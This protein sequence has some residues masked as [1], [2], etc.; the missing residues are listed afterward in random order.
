MTG[1]ENA[2]TAI[3]AI[4]DIFGYF[5]QTLQGADILA[6]GNNRPHYRVFMPDFFNGDTAKIE[7]MPPDNGEKQKALG[8]WPRLAQP[9]L[10]L[11]KIRG[12]LDAAEALDHHIAHWVTIG[13][14]WGGKM[15]SLLAAE[16]ERFRA[17]VQTSPAMIDPQQ[18]KK[19]R[20]PMMILASGDE[21]RDIVEQYAK[22][23]TVAK[24]VE[25]F[26]DQVH[27]F[28]SA[29][30]DLTDEHVRK[31]YHRGYGL[32]LQFFEKHTC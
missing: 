7:W 8:E 31:E 20:V 30:A 22:G 16:G 27:G 24:R 14:C 23:L 19:V 3:L 29:R 10:H 12:L 25:V 21:S 11:P 2:T 4:Y 15:V 5:P 17:A 6:Y 28:M 13:Y 32:A 26:G 18:A 9:E 1:P